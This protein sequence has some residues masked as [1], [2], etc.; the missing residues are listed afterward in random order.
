MFEQRKDNNFV[1]LKRSYFSNQLK[2]PMRFVKCPN[3][4]HYTHYNIIGMYIM[5]KMPYIHQTLVEEKI[6]IYKY[7]I[8]LLY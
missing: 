2:S 5:N 3:C 7:L 8:K 6:K 1:F 4:L